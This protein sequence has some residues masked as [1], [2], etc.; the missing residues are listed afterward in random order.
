MSA[1]AHAFFLQRLRYLSITMA[2]PHHRHQS[3]LEGVLDFSSPQSL[4]P[5]QQDVYCDHVD[6]D[7]RSR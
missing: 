7:L 2:S 5:D 3:S 1:A 6:L 4:E